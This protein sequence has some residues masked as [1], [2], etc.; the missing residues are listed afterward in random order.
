MNTNV[1]KLH[2]YTHCP[3]CG[4]KAEPEEKVCFF[5]DKNLV[6]AYQ[7]ETKDNEENKEIFEENTVK[8]S[9]YKKFAIIF[10]VFSAVCFFTALYLD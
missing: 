3:L 7:E 8:A 1:K 10:L 2:N 4:Q 9:K 6:R 5:C